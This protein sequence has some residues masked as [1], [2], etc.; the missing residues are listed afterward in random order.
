MELG[1]KMHS[2]SQRIQ[3]VF[4]LFTTVLS[5]LSILIALTS[6]LHD[7]TSSP[8]RSYLPSVVGRGLPQLPPIKATA[9]VDKVTVKKSRPPRSYNQRQQDYAHLTFSLDADLRAAW[10]WNVKQLFVYLVLDYP[11]ISTTPSPSTGEEAALSRED[12]AVIADLPTGTTPH[13][14]FAQN[15]VV[16]WDKIVVN[17]RDAKFK[18]SGKK[19]RNKYALGD[20]AGVFAGRNAT[21]TLHWNI[22]PHVGALQWF[23]TPVTGGGGA[24]GGS[25]PVTIRFPERTK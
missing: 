4:G 14:T 2:A 11:G 12:R 16:V 10:H 19:I 20:I 8:P 18:T 21:A 7:P 5:F 6:Y 13:G 23:Q 9:T 25:V 3:S 24:S 1:D 15:E 17:R 22:Q